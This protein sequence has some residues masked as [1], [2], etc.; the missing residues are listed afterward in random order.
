MKFLSI[1]SRITQSLYI[2]SVASV[3]GMLL[4][5]FLN[6]V[7]RYVFN[8]PIFWAEQINAYMLV[9]CVFL[10]MAEIMRRRQHI[11]FDLLSKRWTGKRALAIDLSIVGFALF[12]CALITWKSLAVVT[13]SYRAHVCEFSALPTPIFIPQ[14]FLLTGLVFIGLQFLILFGQDIYYLTRKE[15]GKWK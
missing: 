14:S 1:V 15:A 5:T 8:L 12:W 9:V 10:G 13:F 2:L 7:L 4:L 3:A 6:V 11:R